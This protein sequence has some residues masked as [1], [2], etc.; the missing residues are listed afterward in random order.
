MFRSYL[1]EYRKEPIGIVDQIPWQSMVNLDQGILATT[2]DGLLSGFRLVPYDLGSMTMAEQGILKLQINEAFKWLPAGWAV[3]QHERHV[4]HTDYPSATWPHPVAQLLDDEHRSVMMAPGALWTP[5]T[6]LTLWNRAPATAL[7]LIRQLFFTSP[8]VSMVDDDDTIQTFQAALRRLQDMVRPACRAIDRMDMAGLLTYLHSLISIHQTPVSIPTEDVDIGAYLSDS[9]LTTGV[10]PIL[11]PVDPHTG[12][13]TNGGVY[14]RCLT[15]SS[16]FP[17]ELSMGILRDLQQLNFS[18]DAHTR[19]MPQ[20]LKV[21]EKTTTKTQINY[22]ARRKSRRATLHEM[23]TKQETKETNRHM[24]KQAED[25][26][27]VR[28]EALSHVHALG[29]LTK[30]WVVRHA[31]L[32]EANRRFQAIQSVL[33]RHGCIPYDED[34]NAV[35]AFLSTLPGNIKHNV[36]QH[37]MTT[38]N[39]ADLG[40]WYTPSRGVVWNK[41]LNGP[42]ILQATTYGCHP[43]GLS[44]HV[45]DQADAIGVGPKGSGKSTFLAWSRVQHLRYPGLQATAFDHG[46]SA[47]CLTL[48]LGGGY[49]D[50]GRGDAQMQVMAGID[51]P[52]GYG[53]IY[54]WLKSRIEESG[55]PWHPDIGSYLD[56][57]L[58]ALRNQP[59]WP[60]RIEEYLNILTAHGNRFLGHRWRARE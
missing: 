48:C 4:P 5:E 9:D 25:V 51:Q 50:L 26:D 41:H 35:E 8:P 40:P 13:P 36:E 37:Q 55:I 42:P 52:E 27:Q 16:E 23:L 7:N 3:W 21:A 54:H 1:R 53:R 30:V 28:D 31:D 38:L 39:F 18:Y 56:G 60:R 44:T 45:D 32:A 59:E 12:L 14:L 24:G 57:G 29:K 34:L 10:L 2:D 43:Y 17:D 46:K 15:M 33:H 58:L 11:G 6:Y 47:R 49:Y 20:G 22:L 19:M